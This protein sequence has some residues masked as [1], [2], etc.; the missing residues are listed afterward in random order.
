MK[1]AELVDITELQELCQSFTETTGAATAIL[2]LNGEILSATGWKGICT[3]FHRVNPET[4]QRCLESDTILAGKLKKGSLYNLYQ[5]KNGLYDA[6]IPITI[7]GIHVANFFAGQF[8]LK[9]PD[10]EFFKKQAKKFGFN[11]DEYLKALSE[12]PIYSQAQITSMLDFFSRLARIMGETGLARNELER[13]NTELKKHQEHLIDLVR[14]RTVDLNRAQEIARMGS[15]KWDITTEKVF[16]SDNMYLIFGYDIGNPKEITH[17]F[18]IQCIHPD[19]QNQLLDKL[20]SMIIQKTSFQDE[21]RIITKQGDE[22]TFR[23][24]GEVRLDSDGNPVELFGTNLDITEEKRN[25]TFLLEAKR[26]AE[27]A[28]IAKVQ[29]LSRMSHE[30]RTPLN[31]ILGYSQLL[32]NQSNLTDTQKNQILTIKKSGEHLLDLINEILEVSRI[33]QK[34]ITIENKP[35]NIHDL[36][37]GILE[38]SRVR[39]QEK[40]L[41]L[42]Y[43]EISPV[44]DFLIGD[45]RRI[46]EVLLNLVS[47]AIKYTNDG[48]VTLHTGYTNDQGGLFTGEVIDTGIGIDPEEIDTIFLPF[49]QLAGEVSSTDGAGLGLTIVKQLLELMG[50]T[51]EV[52]SIPGKGSRFYFTMPLLEYTG[53]I[54]TKPSVPEISGYEGPLKIIIIVDDNAINAA[55]LVSALEPLGFIT[56]TATLIPADA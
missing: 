28:N 36:V 43:E 39:A 5:C 53:I 32:K 6:A 26:R 27:E 4:S 13:A 1:F 22:R 51:I 24:Y 12:V 56:H 7:N 38:L 42:L 54:G 15:W 35:F 52:N 49:T 33:E 47:N 30:L 11:T 40:N 20:K 45:E 18:F 55:F 37:K 10:I 3:I 14:E 9:E 46:K 8:L 17:E 19:Y 44:P 41:L 21:I 16:W 2:E 23:I 50:G 34:K 29:F 31:A 48:M 25:E